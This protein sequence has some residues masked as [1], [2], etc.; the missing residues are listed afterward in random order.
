MTRTEAAGLY[1]SMLRI[2]SFEKT[3]HDLYLAGKIPGMSP[4]LY[5]GEEAV[6]ASICSFL[7]P[8]DYIVSNHRGH[9]HCLAKGA[10]M[11]R[12]L[13]EIMGK[14]TGYCR[15]RGGSMHIAD[16]TLGILGANG[17]VGAGVPIANGAAFSIR[18]RGTDQ[19]SVCFFGDAASNQ[20]AFHEATNMAAAMKL[21]LLLV[22]ENNQYGLSTRIQDTCPTSE[23]SDKAHGYG[24]EHQT[25]DGMDAELS[26]KAAGEAVSYV[27][28]NRRPYLIEFVT[29]RFL[30]HGASDNRSYRTREEEEEWK[31]RCPV[32]SLRGKLGPVYGMKPG[33]IRKIEREV[34]K[35][36]AEALKF[37]EDSPDPSPAEALADVF[38]GTGAAA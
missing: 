22:C 27:R 30:G 31:K 21:P 28:E 13:A 10:S 32:E 2:R 11:N 25:V 3:C 18:F 9:G 38:A 37:T 7:K 14:E 20:G 19:V 1:R 24:I 23:I 16:V 4:H 34:E 29:Y 8:D 6:A 12:M 35:E 17:I 15:G 36:V 33:E 26:Y 5:I